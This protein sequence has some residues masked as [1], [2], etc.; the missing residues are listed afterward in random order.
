MTMIK[1]RPLRPILKNK[2]NRTILIWCLISFLS[3]TIIKG[4][5]RP[6]NLHYPKS[7]AFLMDTLPN[8]FAATGICPLLFVYIPFIISGEK[9]K[10]DHLRLI[11]SAL[12][13]LIVLI[14]WEFFQLVWKYPVDILDILM[15]TIGCLLTYI[16]IRVLAIK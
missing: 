7:V 4:V 9:I 16:F 12:I 14:T 8:F 11:L 15:T 1:K 10:K 5:L 3:I 2:N 6:L 13:T